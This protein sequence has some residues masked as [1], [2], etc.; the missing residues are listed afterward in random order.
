MG[1]VSHPRNFI[2]EMEGGP[3]VQGVW[4]G[5]EGQPDSRTLIGE[6]IELH[7]DHTEVAHLGGGELRRWWHN[8]AVQ[9]GVNALA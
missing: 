8:K 9:F 6:A 5:C 4:A 1:G 3:V 7:E 2:D